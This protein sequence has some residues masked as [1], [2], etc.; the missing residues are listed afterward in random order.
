MFVPKNWL[1]I[2]QM[3]GLGVSGLCYDKGKLSLAYL[4]RSEQ[5]RAAGAPLQ[6][7]LR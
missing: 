6:Q 2:H 7:A 4:L 1:L 5:Q 3:I